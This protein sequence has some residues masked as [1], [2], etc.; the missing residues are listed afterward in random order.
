MGEQL[1]L[2]AT[3][4]AHTNTVTTI[5]TLID[6]FNTIVTALRDN[7]IILWKLTEK[8]KT[9]A[10]PP[11]RLTGHSHFIKDAVLSSADQFAL[12]SSWGGCVGGWWC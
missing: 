2:C 5:A 10:V 9:Y 7:F 4:Q 8:D 6:N 3:M 12:S 11:H 1:Q